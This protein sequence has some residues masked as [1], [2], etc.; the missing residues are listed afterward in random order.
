MQAAIDAVA[1]A[2][3]L[4]GMW[5]N[6]MMIVMLASVLFVW[7]HKAARVV[8]ASIFLIMPLAWFVYEQSK[9]VH[10]IG[11]AHLMVWPALAH[12]LITKEIKSKN[13]NPK[14]FYG[15]WLLLFVATILVSLVFDVRD[16]ILVCMGQK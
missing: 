10:L 2:K 5:M 8:L 1:Q 7:W 6:W 4:V 9:N 3:P 14:S 16:V 13:F 11:I 12:Y 15:V